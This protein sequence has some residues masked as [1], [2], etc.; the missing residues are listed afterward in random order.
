MSALFPVQPDELRQRVRRHLTDIGYTVGDDLTV[1]SPVIECKDDVRRLHRHQR[2]ERLRLSRKFRRNV[3]PHLWGRFA[4]GADVTPANITPVLHRA[5]TADDLD[6]FRLATLSWSVPVSSGFGRRIRYLV[7]DNSNGKL[8][9]VFAV[10]DPVINLGVRD[11]DIGWSA[12]ERHARLRH[13][14][15]AYVCGAVPP[16]SML[17][18]GKVIACMIRSSDLVADFKDRYEDELLAL[19]TTSSMGR[20]SQYNRLKLCGELYWRPLGYTEG[21]GHFHISEELFADLRDLLREREHEFADSSMSKSNWRMRAIGFAMRQ[22][23]FRGDF[24]RHGVQRQAFI[25]ATAANSMTLLREGLMVPDYGD[26]LPA[27]AVGR[28]GVDRW[29]IA[30][31]LRQPRDWLRWEVADFVRLLHPNLT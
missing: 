13:V 23:G 16:Y 9:G 20:S 19:T 30:R 5:E 18:G 11:R 15:D 21:Y 3:K 17:L 10:G 7:F 31:S 29:M 14:L 12:D 6:L 8:M 2:D 22:L 25:A 24:M 27:E 28:A 26:L 4:A 1:Q